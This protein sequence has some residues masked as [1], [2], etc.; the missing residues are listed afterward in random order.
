MNVLFHHH[1]LSGGRGILTWLQS[2]VPIYWQKRKPRGSL[3]GARVIGGHEVSREHVR[4]AGWGACYAFTVLR[5]PEERIPSLYAWKVRRWH[6]RPVDPLPPTFEQWIQAQPANPMLSFL[7]T[8]VPGTRVYALG[9]ILEVV[10][11]LGRR[12][13]VPT[14]SYRPIGVTGAGAGASE[15]QRARVR[16]FHAADCALWAD[17]PEKT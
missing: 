9:E 13:S 14:S 2:R 17:L 7:E 16:R 1:P 6:R 8:C 15:R 11:E 10:E 3:Q 12:L 5:N 4:L